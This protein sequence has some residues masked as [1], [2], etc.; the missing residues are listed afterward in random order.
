MEE[1]I[2]YHPLKSCAVIDSRLM[3]RRQIM[4]KLQAT[5]LFEAVS[6]PKTLADALNILKEEGVDVC[7]IGPSVSIASIIDFLK[8]A[9]SDEMPKDCAF[10]GIS[11]DNPYENQKLIEA[12]MHGILDSELSARNLYEGLAKA[13]LLANHGPDDEYLKFFDKDSPFASRYNNIE[14]ILSDS[15]A[16][17]MVIDCF[18]GNDPRLANLLFSSTLHRKK[19]FEGPD[20]TEIESLR[21][22]ILQMATAFK[23]SK[24]YEKFCDYI[25]KSYRNWWADAYEHSTEYA[26]TKLRER[27]MSFHS[28]RDA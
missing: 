10:V 12:G 24:R 27:I 2:N 6:E 14:S 5:A 8:K 21:V 19:A 25:N 22:T 4:Q 9:Q 28:S 13:I 23:G 3:I 20:P 1:V 16:R 11:R 26:N 15:Q 7:I 18:D 17:V